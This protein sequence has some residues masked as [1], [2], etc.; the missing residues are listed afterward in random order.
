MNTIPVSEVISLG[1]VRSQKINGKNAEYKALKENIKS[2]GIQTPITYRKEG[3]KYVVING[4]MRL[5]I[6][7]E[8]KLDEI[9]A[10]ESNGSVDDTT[11]QLS[12]NVFTVGMSYIDMADAIQ[13]LNNDGVVRTKK[14]LATIFGKSSTVIN[15]ALAFVNLHTFIKES[16]ND[17]IHLNADVMSSL[18]NISTNTIAAQE[19]AMKHHLRIEDEGDWVKDKVIT[20]IRDYDWDDQWFSSF[21]NDVESYLERDESKWEYVK[22]CV[23]EDTFRAYERDYGI[24]HEYQ[25]TLF[26]EYAEEQWCQDNDFLLAVFLNETE[27]GRFLQKN[28]IPVNTDYNADATISFNF[29]NKLSSLKTKV[30]KECGVPLSKVEIIGFSSVF[31]PILYV[32]IPKEDAPVI[33]DVEETES[34][35]AEPSDPHKLKYN[36]FNRWAAPI[37]QEHI[38]KNVFAM[39]KDKDGNLIVLD[40]LINVR[41]ADLQLYKPYRWEDDTEPAFHPLHDVKI[42][43]DAHLLEE[44]TSY[45]FTKHYENSTYE[46]LDALFTELEI[47]SIHDVLM[48]RFLNDK[49]ERQK[50]FAVLSKSEL[51][52]LTGLDSKTSKDTLIEQASDVAYDNQDDPEI[53]YFT[54]VC[55]DKG[56]GINTLSNY[57]RK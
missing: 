35:T 11:K 49:E 47:D 1:N 30:K 45:W 18:R 50:Y 41:E 14:D 54:L 21:V 39:Q 28:E 36:K 42:K 34:T 4:H 27:I 9:P 8:L 5:Q 29:T 31:N 13:T 23:G 3:D 20:E 26:E 56:S 7:K 37:V 46:D 16:I 57:L 24:V 17:E 38:K 10:F 6:A 15:N 43:N 2:V 22:N 53:P 44:M 32:N 25:S 48:T 51:V 33:N 55:T 12:T 40:W 19:K 52:E